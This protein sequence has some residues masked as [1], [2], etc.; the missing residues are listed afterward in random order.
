MTRNVGM[1]DRVI[2]AVIGA[3]LIAAFFIWPELE[4]RWAFWIGVLPL[5]SAAVG[6]CPFT[7]CS[8]GGGPTTGDRQR[9]P[10]DA[11]RRSSAAFLHLESYSAA[12]FRAASMGLR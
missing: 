1:I 8:A 11:G 12:C 9:Q 7:S 3:A 6:W 4:Y 10:D 5:A 2:R